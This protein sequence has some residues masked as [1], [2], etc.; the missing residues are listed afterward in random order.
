MDGVGERE[1]VIVVATAND[2]SA[3]DPALSQRPG[4]FDRVVSVGPPDMAMR[5]DYLKRLKVAPEL[6]ETELALLAEASDGF[7]FAH[8]AA[9]HFV[10]AQA[11]FVRPEGDDRVQYVDLESATRQVRNDMEQVKRAGDLNAGFRTDAGFAR[12]GGQSPRR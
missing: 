8:L 4:R 3:L 7:S 12:A 6:S 5:L 10:A 9:M 2:V 11:A 1:G